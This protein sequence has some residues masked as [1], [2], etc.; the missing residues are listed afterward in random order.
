MP[1]KAWNELT[2]QQRNVLEAAIDLVNGGLDAEEALGCYRVICDYVAS[3]KL[4][5]PSEP[6]S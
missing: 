6:V 2:D 4:D 5:E 1:R 3:S